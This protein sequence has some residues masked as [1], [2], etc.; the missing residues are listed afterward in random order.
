MAVAPAAIAALVQIEA[1]SQGSSE[2]T[3]SSGP[4]ATEQ[5]RSTCVPFRVK[6]LQMLDLGVDYKELIRSIKVSANLRMVQERRVTNVFQRKDG[7]IQVSELTTS[8]AALMRLCDGKRT[9][10]EIVAELGP[11]FHEIPGVS[12]EQ[13]CIFGLVVLHQEGLVKFATGPVDEEHVGSSDLKP[14]PLPSYSAPPELSNTQRP[15]PWSTD[16]NV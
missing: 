2:A 8:S 6:D 7:R 16:L 9:V 14:P 15:W 12:A 5:I 1:A 10:E 11:T 3:V 13:A 4:A